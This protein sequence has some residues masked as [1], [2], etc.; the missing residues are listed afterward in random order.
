MSLTSYRAAPPRDKPL[1]PSKTLPER[2]WA[3]ARDGFNHPNDTV[4]PARRAGTLR[5]IRPT[6]A[7]SVPIESERKLFLFILTLFLHVNRYPLRSKTL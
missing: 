3:N 5:F 2:N 7:F 4:R 6:K 1:P